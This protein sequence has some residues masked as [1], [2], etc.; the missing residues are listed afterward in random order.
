VKRAPVFGLAVWITL[1]SV[2]AAPGEAAQ[3]PRSRPAPEKPSPV[4]ALLDHGVLNEG[5]MR[6]VVETAYT[7]LERYARASGA[8]LKLRVD[9]F[10][11]LR[12]DQFAS[13]KWLD[14]VDMPDGRVIDV[15][16]SLHRQTEPGRPALEIVAYIPRWRSHE[17]EWLKAP[18]GASLL[19]MTTREVL[20]QAGE[21]Q[22]ALLRVKAI[23][24]YT[25]SATLAN[26]TRLYRAAFLWIPGESAKKMTF[27]V[28][29]NIVQ[30]VEG[31]LREPVPPPPAGGERK[32]LARPSL[33][34]VD[35]PLMEKTGADQEPR[36]I[37]GST[38]TTRYLSKSG[39]ENHYSGMHRSTANFTQT[40]TCTFD[41][42]QSCSVS[43][44]NTFCEDTGIADFCHRAASGHATDSGTSS[45]GHT[46]PASC[47]AG[48]GCVVKECPFCFCGAEV[49]V[50]FGGP[51][52][53]FN[54]EGDPNWDLSL[55]F[56][57]TACPPCEQIN[58]VTPP[59]G[60]GGGAAGPGGAGGPNEPMDNG[61][62]GGGDVCAC[63]PDGDCWVTFS[64][65][66]IECNGLWKPDK[67]DI[68][69]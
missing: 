26:E 49:S 58:P 20:R 35:L 34:R 62:T 3:R 25:V 48:Y 53:Q 18:W 61:P 12:P 27:M 16:R 68:G 60:T 9:G 45:A 52:V 64:E 42:T 21:K 39:S 17:K 38:T 63:D 54:D 43:M 23:S 69:G 4:S 46:S 65:C 24:T 13:V 56:Q 11:T 37:E 57:S 32:A 1:G 31:A 41:C 22:P 51:E 30:N 15:D 2:L 10:Q 36:C 5:Q 14:L 28:A 29:D 55:A 44:S 67:C 59:S 6:M 40:C 50:S 7:T 19:G 33:P 8:D 47:A 66:V